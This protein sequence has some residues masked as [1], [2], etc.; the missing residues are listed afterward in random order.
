MTALK[1]VIERQDVTK[2]TENRTKAVLQ[3]S[4][5]RKAL[6]QKTRGLLM[7]YEKSKGLK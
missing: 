2:R 5:E 7:L 6:L 3:C 1:Y 4:V